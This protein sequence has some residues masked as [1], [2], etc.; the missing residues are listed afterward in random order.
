MQKRA[1]TDRA[2]AGTAGQAASRRNYLAAGDA[3]LAGNWPFS[4]ASD[5]STRVLKGDLRVGLSFLSAIDRRYQRNHVR[6]RTFTESPHSTGAMSV[7]RR[8]VG[9]FRSWFRFFLVVNGLG[10]MEFAYLFGSLPRILRGDRDPS[11]KGSG[12]PFEVIGFAR[13]RLKP[14]PLV[15]FLPGLIG[16][17][18]GGH[19]D[20]SVVLLGQSGNHN[21]TRRH[22]HEFVFAVEEFAE[23]SAVD[24]KL[25]VCGRTGKSVRAVDTDD[26]FAVGWRGQQGGTIG[27]LCKG[28]RPDEEQRHRTEYEQKACEC[29]AS[30]SGAKRCN[31][32]K[33]RVT[34]LY[35][36]HGKSP[37]L[38]VVVRKIKSEE[39]FPFFKTS[40]R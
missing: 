38:D 14:G 5:S 40:E 16:G 37:R 10:E 8:F 17:R 2:R 31:T 30:S 34:H 15:F 6:S 23:V 32:A 13:F 22:F 33:N 20:A 27:I 28:D 25:I 7:C 39:G 11:C 3:G 24:I 1:S 12:G 18:P 4:R 35:H 21:C 29:L 19:D 36:D 9:V 26:G